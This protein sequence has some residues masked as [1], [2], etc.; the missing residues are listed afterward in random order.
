CGLL[1][2]TLLLW[3]V[4]DLEFAQRARGTGAWTAAT[5]SGQFLS[6]LLVLALGSLPIALVAIG[7]ASVVLAVA[8]PRLGEFTA[9]PVPA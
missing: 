9:Q 5:F 7:A 2:P 1:L 6:P 4:S 8:L 3:V